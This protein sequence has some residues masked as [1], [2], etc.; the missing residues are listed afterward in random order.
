MKE[1]RES[2]ASEYVNS[3]KSVIPGFE[4]SI[5]EHPLICGWLLAKLLGP[6]GLLYLLIEAVCLGEL[7]LSCINFPFQGW[8]AKQTQE[9]ETGF[10]FKARTFSECVYVDAHAL[11]VPS[12]GRMGSSIRRPNCC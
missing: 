6:S 8:I 3:H 7:L 4:S 1:C 11:E 5:L 10:N 2:D 12:R 9:K